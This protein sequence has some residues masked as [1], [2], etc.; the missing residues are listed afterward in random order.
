[1]SNAYDSTE[2]AKAE[3]LKKEKYYDP[4]TCPDMDE[5]GCTYPDCDNCAVPPDDEDEDWEYMDEQGCTY[6]D[7]DNCAVPPDDEDEDWE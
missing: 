3:K 5:Q 4:N 7:C 6:P 2:Q 1:M